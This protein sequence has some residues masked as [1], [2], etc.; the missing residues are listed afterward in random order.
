MNKREA[1]K[2]RIQQFI[3]EH[4]SAQPRTIA[5]LVADEFAISRT[6]ASTHIRNLVTEGLLGYEGE[7]SDRRY[8]RVGVPQAAA[9]EKHLAYDLTQKLDED[10]VWR[11]DIKPLLPDLPKNVVDLWNY[12]ATEIINNAIDHSGGTTLNIDI[13]YLPD[14]VTM[15]I[16]DDGEGIFRRIQRLLG[17]LDERQALFELKKG[18]L[19]TDR[20]RHS[21]Q[22]IFFTSRMCDDFAILSGTLIFLH[23][24]KKEEDWLSKRD[25]G[26][27]GTAVFME[28]DNTT[29]RTAKDV[30]DQYSSDDESYQFSKTAVPV[31][32]AAESEGLVSRSQAKRLLLRVEQFQTVIL[33]FAGVD[34]IGQG[35]ADEIFRV[36]AKQHPTV[37][38]YPLNT[39]QAVS[40]MISRALL[41]RDEVG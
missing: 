26:L 21:G 4:V 14:K 8:Y 27:K 31:R 13:K 39:N 28:I 16:Y 22:G 25:M 40:Q 19:T 38:L 37:K 35:F 15:W 20:T 32:L 23:N 33:D 12:C 2:A 36:F 18:K 11:D 7:T 5:K 17:L 30:H 34:Q 10:I 6:A 3:M 29:S 9:L 24:D 1:R 41:T